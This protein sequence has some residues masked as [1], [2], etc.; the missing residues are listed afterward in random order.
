MAGDR[1]TEVLVDHPKVNLAGF[2]R[3]EM[4]LQE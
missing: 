3:E 2:G 1:R 4:T